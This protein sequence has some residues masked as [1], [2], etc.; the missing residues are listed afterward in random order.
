MFYSLHNLFL[1][2]Q[3]WV[4]Y[5][6]FLIMQKP[7]FYDYNINIVHIIYYALKIDLFCF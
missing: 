1:L 2:F 5:F 4:E 3:V 6:I 7:V